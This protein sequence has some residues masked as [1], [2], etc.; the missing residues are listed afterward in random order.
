L[1]LKEITR[2]FNINVGLGNIERFIIKKNGRILME[3]GKI[4][5]NGLHHGDELLVEFVDKDMMFIRENSG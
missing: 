3:D 1:F 4:E 5:K 2:Q